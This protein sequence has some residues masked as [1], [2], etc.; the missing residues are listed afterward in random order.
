MAS[1]VKHKKKPSNAFTKPC[2]YWPKGSCLKGNSCTFLHIGKIEQ[3][4]AVCKKW[5]RAGLRCKK[6]CKYLHY[7]PQPHSLSICPV[8]TPAEEVISPGTAKARGISAKSRLRDFQ[9]GFQKDPHFYKNWKR[10]FDPPTDEEIQTHMTKGDWELDEDKFMG[11]WKEARFRVTYGS[12]MIVYVPATRFLITIFGN[13]KTPWTDKEHRDY[14][15]GKTWQ[16][17]NRRG[18]S[19]KQ[20][21]GVWSSRKSFA[22]IAKPVSSSRPFK[23]SADRAP[24]VRDALSDSGSEMDSESPQKLLMEIRKLRMENRNLKTL[25]GQKQSWTMKDDDSISN[26]QIFSVNWSW[27][28]VFGTWAFTKKKKKLYATKFKNTNCLLL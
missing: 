4:Y 7:D 22:D 20:R 3:T 2:E 8:A 13:R 6:T 12:I 16:T 9:P 14:Q 21:E 5:K 25:L 23:R 1:R 28:M 10:E 24:I 19:S 17:K 18:F 26:G 15:I 27:T 11:S